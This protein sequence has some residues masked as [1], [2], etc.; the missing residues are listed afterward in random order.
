MLLGNRKEF[1]LGEVV[2]KYI[3]VPLSF[4][5]PSHYKPIQAKSVAK[6]MVENAKI[7]TPG[8]QILFYKEM[9]KKS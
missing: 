2:S 5:V 8:V 9:M 7:E 1:R 6:A 3:F 4:I